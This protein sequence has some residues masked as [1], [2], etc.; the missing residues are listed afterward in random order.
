M[1]YD[2]PMG[3]DDPCDDWSK[4]ASEVVEYL[5]KKMRDSDELRQRDARDIK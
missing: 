4:V 1:P 5:K 3:Y 2:K